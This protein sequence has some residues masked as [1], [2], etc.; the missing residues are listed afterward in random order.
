MH[1]LPN[2]RAIL[3]NSGFA[4]RASP[5][6]YPFAEKG[7]FIACF[8]D[9]IQLFGM[10]PED[11]QQQDIRIIASI[12]GVDTVIVAP[13]QSFGDYN[14]DQIEWN[15]RFVEIYDQN[16]EGQWT[17]DYARIDETEDIAPIPNL[18]KDQEEQAVG[19]NTT[20]SDSEVGV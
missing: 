18:A 12:V 5:L 17:V 6:V 8:S 16:E 15:R 11:F 1:R 9:L 3:G 10:S 4:A 14:Y 13:V 19:R 7:A 2:C 20:L